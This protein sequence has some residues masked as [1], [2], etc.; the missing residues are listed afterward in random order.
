MSRV[1]VSHASA[2]SPIVDKFVDLLMHSLGLI[3]PEIFCTSADGL[4]IETGQDFVDKI[5]ENLRESSPVILFWDYAGV[6]KYNKMLVLWTTS[7]L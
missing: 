4:G 2:D 7:A 1:F 6:K 3:A 5:C